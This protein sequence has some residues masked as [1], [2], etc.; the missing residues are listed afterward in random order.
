MIAKEYK[1]LNTYLRNIFLP[2][3]RTQFWTGLI[4]ILFN[5]A[6]KLL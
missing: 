6:L 3:Q 2:Q 4:I 1:Y 5:K